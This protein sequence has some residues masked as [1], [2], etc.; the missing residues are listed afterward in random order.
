MARDANDAAIAASVIALARAMK[1]TVIAEGVETEEQ[2][3][4][5]QRLGCEQA[6]GFL[7][8]RPVPAEEFEPLF[9]RTDWLAK[10]WRITRLME[11]SV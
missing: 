1:L 11:T 10:S 4:M 9:A 8:S 6:Q 7:Y 3:C 5:L 2:Q